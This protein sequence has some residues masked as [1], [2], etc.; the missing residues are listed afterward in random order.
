MDAWMD[1]W[2]NAWMHGCMD[3]Y[4]HTYIVS[5]FDQD[6]TN[7]KTLLALQTQQKIDQDHES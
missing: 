1:E 3:G 4:K 5:V 2:M 6:E 7:P